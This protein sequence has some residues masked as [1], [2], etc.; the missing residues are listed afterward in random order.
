MSVLAE[1]IGD[2]PDAVTRFV[3]VSRS[4]ALPEP[5]GADKTSVI[6]ELPADEPGALL[7]LLEQ[8]ATRR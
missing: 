2:N 5:T 8:F 4:R 6:A 3:H 1:R 7:D